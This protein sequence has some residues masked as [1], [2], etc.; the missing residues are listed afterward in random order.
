MAMMEFFLHGMMSWVTS[1]SEAYPILSRAKGTS[2]FCKSYAKQGRQVW[3][4]F[5][6]CPVRRFH[7]DGRT[8]RDVPFPPAFISPI[9]GP[10]IIMLFVVFVILIVVPLG[11]VLLILLINRNKAAAGMALPAASPLPP[12][13]PLP[14]QA[15]SRAQAR[16]NELET[17]KQQGLIS[18]EEYDATRERILGEM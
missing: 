3:G 7:E 1:R 5:C 9:G 15:L 17:L 8:M 6:H 10:E 4:D 14:V 18:T 12:P 13:P 11:I 2:L 16:L